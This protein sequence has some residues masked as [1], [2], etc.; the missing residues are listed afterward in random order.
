MGLRDECG[1][2][3]HISDTAALFFSFG[4]HQK[5]H[6]TRPAQVR[7]A[8]P[9]IVSL[10]KR[11]WTVLTPE[12]TDGTGRLAAHLDAA[13]NAF[14]STILSPREGEIVRMILRGHSSKAIAR[15]FDNSPETIKVHRRRVYTKLQIASQGELLSLFLSALSAAPPSSTKDPLVHFN[16]AQE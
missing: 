15:A 12:R 8:L 11:H 16:I 3:I 6:R 4:V 2:M 1:L 5:G 9:F 10:A 7:M 14:G 13:F